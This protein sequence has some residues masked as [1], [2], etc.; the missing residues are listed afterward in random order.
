MCASDHNVCRAQDL[1]GIFISSLHRQ[2]AKT[3][4]QAMDI[5]GHRAQSPENM[6]N[7][8]LNA[9]LL[10]SAFSPLMSCRL[11]TRLKKTLQSGKKD[12]RKE[13]S[14]LYAA[15]SSMGRVSKEW[16]CNDSSI[17]G[18]ICFQN[19]QEKVFLTEHVEAVQLLTAENNRG[20][21]LTWSPGET[22]RISETK[23]YCVLLKQN[24]SLGSG[25]C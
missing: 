19:R 22:K 18:W 1:R 12:E 7:Q 24:T 10:F 3:H 17:T 5:H 21:M 9:E 8:E 23:S 15:T 4:P 13:K 11:H 20:W 25:T 14:E 16:L 6:T 2:G